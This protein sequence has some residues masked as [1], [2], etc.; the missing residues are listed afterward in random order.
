[1]RMRAI[2]WTKYGPPDVLQLQEVERPVPKDNEVLLSIYAAGGKLREQSGYRLGYF[3]GGRPARNTRASRQSQ[4]TPYRS[5]ACLAGPPAGQVSFP[6]TILLPLDCTGDTLHRFGESYRFVPG[7]VS[8][9]LTLFLHLVINKPPWSRYWRE[10][11][12]LWM[13]HP[14]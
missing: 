2:V 6:T 14:L 12:F 8:A 10:I 1:M 11:C 4:E 7:P 5:L 13:G 9:L 3:T